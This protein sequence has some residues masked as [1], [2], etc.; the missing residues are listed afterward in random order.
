MPLFDLVYL[1]QDIFGCIL[2]RVNPQ[3]RYCAMGVRSQL[4]MPHLFSEIKRKIIGV[5]AIPGLHQM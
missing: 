4:S 3:S 1:F 2:K 5:D